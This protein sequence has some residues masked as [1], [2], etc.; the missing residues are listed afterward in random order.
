M[1]IVS[2]LLVVIRFCDRVSKNWWKK[3]LSKWKTKKKIWEEKENSA[4]TNT[5]T[6]DPWIWYDMAKVKELCDITMRLWKKSTNFFLKHHK[7]KTHF[8]Y[9]MAAQ[10]NDSIV[11]KV[12]NKKKCVGKKCF[13]EIK[14]SIESHIMKDWRH[15]Q[16]NK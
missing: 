8:K 5:Q 7:I 11:K 13:W 9:L 4:A 1:C 6:Q 16:K 12:K 2:C 15:T 3:K 14:K 10:I